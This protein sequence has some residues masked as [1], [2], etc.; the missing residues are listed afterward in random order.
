M[1][2]SY[3]D[4]K[5]LRLFNSDGLE[6]YEDDVRF[7]QSK[8]IL[9]ISLGSDFKVNT[10]YSEYQMIRVLGQGGFG[11]V[12]LGVHKKT[13]QKVAIKVTNAGG[14]ENAEDI[15]NIFSESETVKALNHPNIVKI[16]NFF[17]IKKT[18][19]TYCIMEY[20]EGGEL[21][22]Y[23]KEVQR[24]SETLAREIFHQ[25]I[26]AIDYCHKQKIIHRDLK[27]ENI[28]KV[29]KE[30][31]EVKIVDFGIAGL[32]AGRK[33]EITKAGSI[34]YLPPEIFKQKNVVASPALDIW[35]IGCILFAL[36]TGYLPF[37]DKQESVII[38]KIQEQEP[39]YPKGIKLSPEIKD[40]IVQLLQ[41][42][43]EKR[44]K[45]S[46]IKQHPWFLG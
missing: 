46:V 4:M 14:L 12:Y 3:S 40:L 6:I 26:S 32:Y 33:S 28:L 22:D 1:N 39:E 7:L 15:E 2:F 44:A 18:L 10:Y 36:V 21:L 43:S 41:K 45:I 5:K 30:S 37:N 8:D 35:A 42:N 23:L 29:N 19:Q 38:Q 13:K 25:I 11:Q 17:V 34:N 20:L 9:Y 24:L 31:N 27:L 16:Y